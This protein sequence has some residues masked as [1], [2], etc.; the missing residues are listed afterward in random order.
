MLNPSDDYYS[1]KSDLEEQAKRYNC[2]P[3]DLRL[4]LYFPETIKW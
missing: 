1:L 2:S 3:D 4:D